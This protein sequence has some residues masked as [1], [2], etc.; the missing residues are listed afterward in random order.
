M[1]KSKRSLRKVNRG[2]NI[3]SDDE[4]KHLPTKTFKRLIDATYFLI[5]NYD[6][7][8]WFIQVGVDGYN[9]S[10]NFK[11]RYYFNTRRNVNGHL[12][13]ERSKHTHSNLTVSKELK[14]IPISKVDFQYYMFGDKVFNL[15]TAIHQT[16]EDRNIEL[17][18]KQ[19]NNL[20]KLFRKRGCTLDTPTKELVEYSDLTNERGG[21]DDISFFYW[22]DRF[23][24]ERMYATYVAWN[25]SELNYKNK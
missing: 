23:S 14:Q 15:S 11:Y 3:F 13:L 9:Y 25:N 16:K 18:N 17:L 20:I 2:Y 24:D 4:H 12:L 21:Y 1:K 19:M 10:S 8:E 5:N 6:K 7:Y 22:S